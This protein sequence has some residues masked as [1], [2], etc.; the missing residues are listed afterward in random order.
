MAKKKSL[1]EMYRIKEGPFDDINKQL[2]TAKSV[3][4]DPRQS[5]GQQQR[6]NDP[7]VKQ[8]Q[9][10][11]DNS[12]SIFDEAPMM[13]AQSMTVKD[14]IEFLKT[15]KQDALVYEERGSEMRAVRNGDVKPM[16][17]V[18]MDD[19]DGESINGDIIVFGAW[20]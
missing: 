13:P 7:A 1:L 9:G 5:G 2:G 19:A 14:L 4:R 3:A 16:A 11:L 6:S 18:S 12:K 17:N 8:A 10:D 20:A 15:Q